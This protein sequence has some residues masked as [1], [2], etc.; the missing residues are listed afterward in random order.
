MTKAGKLAGSRSRAPDGTRRGATLQPRRL[1]L[2][3]RTSPA[4]SPRTASTGSA[5]SSQQMSTARSGPSPA[6]GLPL[7]DAQLPDSWRACTAP[8]GRSCTWHP[9]GTTRVYTGRMRAHRR[10]QGG[11]WQASWLQCSTQASAWAASC[12][13]LWTL[14][15]EAV[16]LLS[17][18]PALPLFFSALFRRRNWTW[19]RTCTPM[20]GRPPGPSVLSDTQRDI[21]PIRSHAAQTRLLQK[22]LT[23]SLALSSRLSSNVLARISDVSAAGG[24]GVA[25]RMSF[26]RRRP[27]LLLHKWP[28]G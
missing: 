19:A 22:A 5:Q 10:P 20:V 27:Q 26:R 16:G 11:T 4:A 18:L 23:P 2:I 3:T 13:G 8:P 14:M 9:R 15:S 12:R 28:A 1:Y 17:A 7:G 21:R 6:V 25:A 24:Q